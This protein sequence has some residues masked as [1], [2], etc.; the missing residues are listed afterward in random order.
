MVE[1]DEQEKVIFKKNKI[2]II[3]IKNCYYLK[4]IILKF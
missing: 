1:E 4:L 2:K 3:A